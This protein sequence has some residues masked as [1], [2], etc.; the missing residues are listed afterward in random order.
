VPTENA[1]ARQ[2]VRGRH[3]AGLRSW[4]QRLGG[5][6]G[7]LGAVAI[8]AVLGPGGM[9]APSC[10]AW[11]DNVGLAAAAVTPTHPE[12]HCLWCCYICEDSRGHKS[13][14]SYRLLIQPNQPLPRCQQYLGPNGKPCRQNQVVD[15]C[16]FTKPYNPCEAWWAAEG[17]LMPRA[18]H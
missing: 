2:R 17:L 15:L 12:P 3:A 8:A 9:S 6:A 13:G 4:P 18:R 1:K 14:R 5:L 11:A 10:R 7:L 16:S